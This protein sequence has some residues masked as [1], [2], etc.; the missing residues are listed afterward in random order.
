M[1]AMCTW[2]TPQNN[3][4]YPKHRQLNLISQKSAAIVA[5][6]VKTSWLGKRIRGQV[7]NFRL[8]R[9][10][11]RKKTFHWFSQF[12]WHHVGTGRGYK[13]DNLDTSIKNQ[14]ITAETSIK[15]KCIEKPASK[16]YN[17]LGGKISE[18]VIFFSLLIHCTRLMLNRSIRWREQSKFIDSICFEFLTDATISPISCVAVDKKCRHEAFAGHVEDTGLVPAVHRLDTRRNVGLER[19]SRSGRFIWTTNSRK[20]TSISPRHR[21]QRSRFKSVRWT[22]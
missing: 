13:G 7:N 3:R 11:M 17:L 14:K 4:F 21:W 12:A 2:Y 19:R 22:R 8:V 5:D 6:F 16:C 15:Y 20:T 9:F 1:W 18:I 10:T